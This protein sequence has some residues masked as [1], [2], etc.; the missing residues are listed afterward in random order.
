MY[1]FE[2]IQMNSTNCRKFFLITLGYFTDNHSQKFTLWIILI[3]I[4]IICDEIF[5]F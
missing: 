2:W 4:N 3:K 5:I 1:T